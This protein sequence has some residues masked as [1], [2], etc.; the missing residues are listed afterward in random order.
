MTQVPKPL[1]LRGRRRGWGLAGGGQPSS[2]V[3][4]FASRIFDCRK[5]SCRNLPARSANFFLGFT[6]GCLNGCFIICT[7]T[8]NK[9]PVVGITSFEH[10][11]PRSR[12]RA[13]KRYYQDL[14]FLHVICGSVEDRRASHAFETKRFSHLAAPLRL[15]VHIQGRPCVVGLLDS[16][17]TRDHPLAPGSIGGLAVK[18]PRRSDDHQ[19]I[20]RSCGRATNISDLI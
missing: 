13:A 8:G 5:S 1:P 7:T 3:R 11:R 9:L 4:G 18:L 6:L 10:R 2:I 17:A 16:D 12:H 14:G 15:D 20:H 19:N